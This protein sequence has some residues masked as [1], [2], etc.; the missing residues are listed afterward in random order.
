MSRVSQQALARAIKAVRAM[1]LR[2]KECLADE[3][4][5]AQPA[6]FGSV[7]VLQRM[8]VSLEK[9]DFALDL[10]FICFQAMK[11]TGLAWPIITEAELD[12]QM[13]RYVAA[14]R[15]GEELSA[16]QSERAMLQYLQDH[17]EKDLLAFVTA[18]LNKWQ[19]VIVPEE[20]DKFLMLAVANL[21]NCIG[22]APLS[23]VGK[24]A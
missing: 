24:K 17:P 3:L 8:G 18:E 22:F 11:E 2:H 15:F 20:T 23:R 10:L 4:F 6:M 1:D 9:M 5:R 16:A 21:V 14:V 7:L 12:K 19:A 13:G